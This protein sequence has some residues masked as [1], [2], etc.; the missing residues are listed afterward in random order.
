MLPQSYPNY[1]SVHRRFQTWCRDEVSTS[2]AIKAPSMKRN[3]SSMRLYP[4]HPAES[5]PHQ[6]SLFSQ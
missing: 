1:K 5:H 3:A 2:F 6:Q 4:G